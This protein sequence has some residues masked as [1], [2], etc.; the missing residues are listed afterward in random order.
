MTSVAEAVRRVY[1]VFAAY[2]RPARIAFCSSCYDRE[3]RAYFETT[4]LDRFEPDMKRRLASEGADHWE[5]V[6]AYKHYLPAILEAI[7]PPLWRDDLY[8]EQQFE[9]L[10]GRKVE[11]WPA[12][13]R[14]VLKDFAVAVE[15]A[16]RGS[17]EKAA[18]DWRAAAVRAFPDLPAAPRPA[19]PVRAHPLA[20]AGLSVL[21]AALAVGA[22]GG[23][24][25][26]RG[27]AAGWVALGLSVA[28]LLAGARTVRKAEV[29]A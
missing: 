25:L 1:A 27:A 3:E 22:W 8:P 4:A 2:P 6:E 12:A 10:R 19:A 9:I 20:V 7:A 13:E 24:L 23:H 5:T 17:S 29:K 11:T 28:G 21:A 18:G 26:A 15:G 16:L 14:E